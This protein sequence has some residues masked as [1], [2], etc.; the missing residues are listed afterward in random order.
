MADRIEII[1]DANACEGEE[2][3]RILEVDI[4]IFRFD[5]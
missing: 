2:G 3:M 1:V 5:F 4:G